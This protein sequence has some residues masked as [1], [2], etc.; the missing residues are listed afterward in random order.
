LITAILVFF[1][2]PGIAYGIAVGTIKNDKDVVKHMTSSMKGLAGYIVL[3][4]FAGQFVYYFKNSN[5][6]VL[7]AIKGAE[8]LET[9]GFTGI[10][11]F[12]AFVAV[13]AVI[14]M[15]MGSASAKWAIMAPIFVPM[16][17]LLGYHPGITQAA[18]RIGDSITNIITPMMSYFALIVAYA[19]KYNERYG[20]GTIIATM[21]PYSVVLAIIWT[22]LLAVWMFLGLPT[23]PDAPLHMP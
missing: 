19:Q 5:M 8:L 11:L 6:G 15:F 22:I 12:I 1:L 18:F 14:N 20:M 4:F 10:W 9:I 7:L 2:V 21:L 17:M 16:F 13:S 3:V 23:G